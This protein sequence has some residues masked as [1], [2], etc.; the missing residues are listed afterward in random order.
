MRFSRV[1]PTLCEHGACIPSSAVPSGRYQAPTKRM[2]GQKRGKTIGLR[3]LVNSA[4]SIPPRRLWKYAQSLVQRDSIVEITSC[5]VLFFA[6]DVDRSSRW[7]GRPYSPLIDSLSL[8]LTNVGVATKHVSFFGSSLDMAYPST[9]VHLINRRYLWAYLADVWS[10]LL[11]RK[12]RPG[13]SRFANVQKLYA[14]IIDRS[15]A[16]LVVT[17]G[18]PKQLVEA[19]HSA[20]VYLVEVLHG[21]GYAPLPWDYADRT[22]RELP[23]EFWLG[24]SISLQTFSQLATKG[25]KNTLIQPLQMVHPECSSNLENPNDFESDLRDSNAHTSDEHRVLTRVLIVLSRGGYFGAEIDGRVEDWRLIERLVAESVQTVR[26]SFRL[27]PLHAAEGPR[28]PV[29]RRVSRLAKRYE[30]CG[31]EWA[32]TSP[33]G[34]VYAAQDCVVTWGSEAVF[35][36]YFSGTASGVILPGLQPVEEAPGQHKALD[37]LEQKGFLT[38][39]KPNFSEILRWINLQT[40]TIRAPQVEHGARDFA[41]LVRSC[42]RHVRAANA[43]K[44]PTIKN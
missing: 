39:L 40:Q 30:N 11:A 1:R 3:R 33:P 25:V 26:W 29:F 42:V 38:F 31:W 24:D 41:S 43:T 34:I 20:N 35:D 13:Y 32:T 8:A 12:R 17:I 19:A 36:A 4:A 16:K 9:R 10:S 44:L 14:E 15:Q 28:S 22:A 7:S 5:D 2:S 27:H 6:H 23:N 37:Y 18:L 21:F